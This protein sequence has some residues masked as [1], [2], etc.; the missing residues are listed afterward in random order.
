MTRYLAG[1]ASDVRRVI[2]EGRTMR[3][4]AGEAGRAEA[5]H[6]ALFDEF[7]ARNATAAFHEL[8]WE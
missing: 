6:W 2:R 5:Q 4:A 7:N 1:L 8:E 3:D